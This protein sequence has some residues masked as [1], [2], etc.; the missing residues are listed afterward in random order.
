MFLC[1]KS[2]FDMEAARKN[3]YQ[4]SLDFFYGN[5]NKYPKN[6]R[7]W[8]G[9]SNLPWQELRTTLFPPM[10]NDIEIWEAKD[11]KITPILLLPVGNCF[12]ISNY[13]NVLYFNTKQNLSL[14]FSDPYRQNLY[15]SIFNP[16]F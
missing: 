4:W 14:F 6:I 9:T 7:S 8:S 10:K 15:R 3:G 16:Q 12:E 5:V 13:S 2:G 1:S 11:T